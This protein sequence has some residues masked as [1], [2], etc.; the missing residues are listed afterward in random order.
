MAET[1]AG[2][3]VSTDIVELATHDNFW[4]LYQTQ[5]RAVELLSE[6]HN[7]RTLIAVVCGLC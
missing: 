1:G 6:P 5:P 7:I 3:V 4:W 2:L